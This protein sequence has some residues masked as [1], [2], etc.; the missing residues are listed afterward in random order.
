MFALAKPAFIGRLSLLAKINLSIALTFLIVITTV[1]TVS[2]HRERVYM[3]GMARDQVSD[4]TTWYFDSLNTMMLTGTM[5]QRAILR[6]KLLARP[7]VVEAR[8]IRGS[9]VAEQFGAGFSDEVA[10]DD[11]DLAALR[12]EEVFAVQDHGGGRVLTVITPFRATENTRGVNCLQCHRVPTGAVNGAIRVSYSLEDLDASAAREAWLNAGA[13]LLLFAV[14]LMLVNVLL[15]RWV[16]Q[17]LKNLMEAVTRRAAGDTTAHAEAVHDDELGRL[18]AAFNTMADNVVAVTAREHQAA[19]ELQHKVD[20]L[21]HVV[22]RVAEG[23]FNAQIGFTGNDAVGELAV[24]LRIMIDFIRLSIDEKR[25]AVETLQRQVDRILTVVTAA[26]EGDLT[27]EV[28]VEGDDAI[29]ALA[30]GVQEMIDSLNTLAAQVQLSGAQVTS[31][32]NELASSVKQLDSTAVE[33]AATT[34]Q[35]A[36]TATEISATAQK[37]ERTMDEVGDVAEMTTRSA[38][39]SQSGLQKMEATM[40][41][42]V[43]AAGAVAE[44]L[45]VM[46]QKTANIGTVVTTI[47]KI[48]DQTNLLSLNAAIEAEK[49]GEFG[50]GFS[51]VAGEIRRLADQTAVFTLDI[52]QMVREMQAAVTAGVISMAKFT[53]QVHTS[54]REVQEVSAQQGR[55]VEQVQT[56][57]PRFESARQGMH[58]QS[59]GAQQINQAMI[60]LNDAA[61]QTVEALRLSRTAIERL[62]DAARG[63]QGVVSKFKVVRHGA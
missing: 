46:N 50:R 2:A 20:A 27:G 14:G 56:L 19:Q 42:V 6:Q 12:G 37:L 5:A 23:D 24:S 21:L 4:L 52:E 31:A 51:V 10:L 59:Q 9:P 22:N 30:R 58:F 38:V 44:R 36:T 33:H 45:E 47:T 53:D 63:L 35:I 17:P 18:A 41:Q 11:L 32:G 61:H 1:T 39:N 28:Q 13:N 26:A 48:A 7:G 40:R 29:G 8:V 55:I 34:H 60:Q 43:A 62:N 3:L 49:A 25:S 16:T 54:V 57:V 15:H